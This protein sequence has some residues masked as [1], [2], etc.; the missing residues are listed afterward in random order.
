MVSDRRTK[1]KNVVEPADSPPCTGLCRISS[2]ALTTGPP[3][4]TLFISLISEVQL[5]RL[6]SATVHPYD[7]PDLTSPDRQL[8]LNLGIFI[9]PFQAPAVAPLI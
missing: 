4:E 2:I 1:D 5:V 9:T 3:Y 6:R 7:I 8:P